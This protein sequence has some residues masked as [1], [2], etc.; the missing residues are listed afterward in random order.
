MQ[1]GQKRRAQVQACKSGRLTTMAIAKKVWTDDELLRLPHEGKV[2]VVD[3]ELKVMTPAGLEQEDV[4]A[5]L[6][7]HLVAYV[8]LRKLGRVYMS[9]AGFRK[10]DGELR[11]PDVSFV[12]TEKLPGGRSPKKFGNFPPDLAVEIL[13]EDETPQDYEAKVQEYLDWGTSLVWVIDHNTRT[14]WVYHKDLTPKQLTEAYE[15]SGE[16]IISGFKLPVRVLFE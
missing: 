3:G 11:A 12:R 7:A 15:L 6:V 2:E 9:Q 14:V 16:D 5:T 13:A 8:H 4:G 10:P 1:G